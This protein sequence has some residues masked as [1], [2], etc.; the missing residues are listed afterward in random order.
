MNS[1]SNPG[2]REDE[3]VPQAEEETR[4]MRGDGGGRLRCGAGA[5]HGE[6]EQREREEGEAAHYT[7]GPLYWM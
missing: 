7:T 6:G 3:A 1:D 5:Q 4:G 2:D